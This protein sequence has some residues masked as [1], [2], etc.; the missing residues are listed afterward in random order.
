LSFRRAIRDR[1][2][3]EEF[4]RKKNGKE[5]KKN[6]AR[7]LCNTIKKS[8]TVTERR[9]DLGQCLLGMPKWRLYPG[10]EKGSKKRKTRVQETLFFRNGYQTKM[11][12]NEAVQFGAKLGTV[13]KQEGARKNARK[14]SQ[15]G[16]PSI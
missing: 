13:S 4:L 12:P 9:G 7:H 11:G 8:L 1:V 14:R 5:K 2:Q 15:A 3:G 16:I 6:W 10:E